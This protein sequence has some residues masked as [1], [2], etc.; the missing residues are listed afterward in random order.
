MR[1]LNKSKYKNIKVT[2]DGIK[3]DSTKEANR[4]VELKYL[5]KAGKIK[6]LVLQPKFLLQPSYKKNG[7]TIRKIEYVADF[8]YLDI[9]TNKIYIEDVKG[10]KTDVYKLKK[11]IFEYNYPE[12]VI[13]EI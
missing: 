12:L 11:K 5:E 3:F 2:I 6:D 13:V 7:K 1:Y 8:S 9:K 4:Y 10:M